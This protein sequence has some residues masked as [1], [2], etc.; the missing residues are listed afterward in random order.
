M[1]TQNLLIHPHLRNI[2]M[3]IVI[4]YGFVKF[5]RNTWQTK[6]MYGNI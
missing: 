5:V 4:K 3:S 1:F 6:K 2:K